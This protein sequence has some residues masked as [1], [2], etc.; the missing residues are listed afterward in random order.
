MLNNIMDVNE[1]SLMHLVKCMS[2]SLYMLSVL[3][4]A[5]KL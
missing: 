3:K 4:N 5:L 2:S 1:Y